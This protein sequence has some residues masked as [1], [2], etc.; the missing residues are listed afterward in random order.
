MCPIEFRI[1]DLPTRVEETLCLAALI[2]AIVARLRILRASNLG[3]RIYPRNLIEENKW[4]AIRHGIH[5]KLIDFG[6]RE[7]V[8]FGY[9]LEELLAFVDP[10]VDELGSRKEVEYAM[11]IFENG[12]S[13]DR[14]LARYEESGG[15]FKA[16]VDG[17]IAETRE[18]VFDED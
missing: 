13:A 18:G 16:V 10:V 12:T 8:D 4:R 1:C 6:K 3:F 17:L 11:T 14:Q 9:L 7:E 15:D 2:Q 5:G